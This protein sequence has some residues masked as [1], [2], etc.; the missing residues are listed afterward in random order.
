MRYTRGSTYLASAS[1]SDI[2]ICGPYDHL[3]FPSSLW[4]RSII[5]P[6]VL[7]TS[8]GLSRVHVSKSIL[9]A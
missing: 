3:I 7:C 4:P 5:F 9:D 2:S 8:L 1:P 6:A